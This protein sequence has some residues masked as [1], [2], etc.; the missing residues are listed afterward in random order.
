MAT[1]AGSRTVSRSP[2]AGTIELH[3]RDM[4][5]LYNSMDPSPFHERDLHPDAEQFICDWAQEL[6]AEVPVR[7]AIA[8]DHPPQDPRHPEIITDAIHGHFQRLMET[9]RL[10]LRRLLKDGRTSLI[11]GLSCLVASVLGGELIVRLMAQSP[12]TLV[13]RE[14]LLIGGWVAMWRPIEIF[15]YDWWPIRNRRRLF[16]RLSRAQITVVQSAPSE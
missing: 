8:V 10:Q 1:F 14:S 2:T 3:V 15:L 16:D 12:P 6:S 11:I 4:E 9:S 5:Q 7:L 13:I